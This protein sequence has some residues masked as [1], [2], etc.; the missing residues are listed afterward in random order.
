MTDTPEV[1]KDSYR[2]FWRTVQGSKPNRGKMQD[3]PSQN[4]SNPRKSASPEL[5]SR[6]SLTQPDASASE[7][8][9]T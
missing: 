5:E 6:G 4:V 8:V 3:D 2:D 9:K 7:S 1:P